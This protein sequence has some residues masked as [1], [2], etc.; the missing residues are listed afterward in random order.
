MTWTPRIGDSGKPKYQALVDAIEADIAAGALRDGERLPP[1]RA[2]A[3]ALGVTIA[4]VT[5]AFGEATRRGLVS[6]RTGSGTFVRVPE[7]PEAD[8]AQPLDLSLNTVP[9]GPAK[10]F[11]VEVL[12]TIAADRSAGEL[13]DYGPAAGTERHRKAMA[14]W[15][16]RRLPG[17]R[18]AEVALTHGAQHGLS[19]CFAAFV[20]PGDTVLCETWTYTGIRR[21]AA[22]A[23]ARLVGVRTDAE[24][25]CPDS[26]ADEL[27]RTGARV[28]MCSPAVHNPTA[29]TMSLAR[30]QE[31]VAVCRRFDALVVE[32]D[33]YGMV[34]GDPAATLAMLD[35]GR[36]VYVSSVS[37]CVS[38]G[39]RL[40]LVVS[41]PHLAASLQDKLVALHWTA[42]TFC[43]EVF[44]R[45][46]ET[47]GADGCV[48]EHQ[49]EMAHR[50]ELSREFL[51]EAVIPSLPSYHL[52][53][54]APPDW[55]LDDIVADLSGRGVRVSPSSNFL[56][57]DS[58]TA[59]AYVRAC[60]GAVEDVTAL[61]TALRV[62]AAV[63]S[64]RPRLSGTVV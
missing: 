60:L 34:S 55:R 35:P 57:D 56:V 32:D 12:S 59:P 16:G 44:T 25:L 22:S 54:K 63:W 40:G 4:T 33:I 30:R 21:L 37:K 14:T 48:A 62:V 17:P 58:R 49:R 24:G 31:M 53:L 45:L 36:A 52:W 1:Q 61:S 11:L 64:S 51:G 27:K 42:P 5:R 46:V 9:S 39:L 19:A 7:M 10:P 41:P 6:A 23:H 18:L 43:A 26:L 15:F 3:S 47:G 8:P 29:A 20:R 28:V 13:F 50:L 38:P 2:I